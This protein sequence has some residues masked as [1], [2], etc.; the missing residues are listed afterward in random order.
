MSK[1]KIKHLIVG[2]VLGAATYI[3][4]H[5]MLG[6]VISTIIFVGKEVFDMYKPQPTGF[7]KVDLTV[8]YIGLVIGFWIAGISHGLFNLIL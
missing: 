1:D 7:D 2:A 3:S 5:W 4:G 8:D 6:F